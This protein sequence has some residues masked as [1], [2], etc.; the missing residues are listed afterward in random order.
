[1]LA[2]HR[3]NGV[4]GSMNGSTAAGSRANARLSTAAGRNADVGKKMVRRMP[5]RR[6]VGG[7][8][9]CRRI[10]ERISG[11]ALTAIAKTDRDI[12]EMAQTLLIRFHDIG[13]LVVP[14]SSNAGLTV[15]ARC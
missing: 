12:R 15:A 1:V 6:T 3:Q 4:A 10:V 8:D 5:T 11:G 13:R 7:S 14:Q 9:A 2:D